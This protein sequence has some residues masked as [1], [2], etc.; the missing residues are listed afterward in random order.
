[1]NNVISTKVSI[2]RNI[3][4]YKFESKLAK[5]QRIEIVENLKNVL[6]GK[7]T[8]VNLTNIDATALK[9]LEDNNLTVGKTEEIFLDKKDTL[10]INMFNGEHITIVSTAEGF[11]EKA[12]KKAIEMSQFLSNKINFAYSDEFGFLMSDITKVGCGIKLESEIMLGAIKAINK[13]EQ[14][15]QNI[16]KLGYTL[17]ETKLP[18]IYTLSTN[19]NLGLGEKKVIKDF[20]NTLSKLQDLEIESAKMLDVS[21]HDEIVDKTNR[22]VAILNSAYLLSYDELLNLVIN[23]RIGVNLGVINFEESA[24]LKLQK[25]VMSKK[26]DFVSQSEL[27]E[28]ASRVKQILKGE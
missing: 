2:F 14:V 20:E 11:S 25:L 28:L 9:H 15:K 19:C 5:E 16:F 12:V 17:K 21:K 8:Y 6:A 27:K 22:S 18:S 23:V 3:K 7:A 13:I 26:T 4:D 10:S 1:M 24:L